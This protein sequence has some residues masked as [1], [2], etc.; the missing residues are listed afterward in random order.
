M[1]RFSGLDRRKLLNAVTVFLVI[2]LILSTALLL[3]SLWER[4]QGKFSSPNSGEP[5]TAISYNGT[6]YEL[7]DGIETMLIMGLDKFD[8]AIDNSA[9]NNDQQADFL[10]LLVIDNNSSTYTGIHINRDTMADINVLGVAGEKIDTVNQQIALSHTYG[11]GKE[12]SC[13]NT[14]DAVSDLLNNVKIDHY[15]SLTMDAVP[16]IADAVGGVE[17][18][19][20]DDFT[21]LDDTLIKGQTVSLKGDHALNYIRARQGLEDSSNESRMARQRQFLNALYEECVE[22][23]DAD[24]DFIADVS[25]KLSEQLISDC[26]AN[27]L[28]KMFKKLTSYKFGNINTIEGEFKNGERFVEFYADK[29]SVMKVVIEAFYKEKK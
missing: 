17:V 12:I 4:Q 15:M 9:Y 20:L 25:L 2:V 29:D 10:M 8:E 16:I 21:G 22:M 13:R 18:E 24:E 14:A 5:S 28:Q 3:V 27:K 19:V 6:E 23:Q 7:R 1:S 11:N 26:S